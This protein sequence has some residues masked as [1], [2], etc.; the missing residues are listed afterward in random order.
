VIDEGA[1][2][3]VSPSGAENFT[4]CGLKWFLE[5]SGGTDV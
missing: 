5:K 2:V 1:L 4:E 3:P